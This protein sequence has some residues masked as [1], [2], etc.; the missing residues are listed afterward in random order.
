MSESTLRYPSL[1]VEGGG[2]GIVSHAGAALLL[3]AGEKT[4]LLDAL[5]QALVPWRKPLATH[6]PG[7]IQYRSVKVVEG[8]VWW[9]AACWLG[10]A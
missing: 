10:E 5:S 1:S 4:G 3:R 9:C 8:V 2:T 6:D 7:K